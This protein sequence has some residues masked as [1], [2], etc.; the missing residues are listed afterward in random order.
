M[1]NE[2]ESKDRSLVPSYQEGLL[3]KSPD[4][5]RRGMDLAKT[6]NN[7]ISPIS[8][9]DLLV[10]ELEKV[11][12]E[13]MQSEDFEDNDV[14]D[15]VDEIIKLANQVLV[16]VTPSYLTSEKLAEIY[17]IRGFAYYL[18][19]EHKQAIKDYSKAIELDK[20]NISNYLGR[21]EVYRDSGKHKKAIKDYSRAIEL[22]PNSSYIYY[23]RGCVYQVLKDYKRAIKDYSRAIEINPDNQSYFNSREDVYKVMGELSL[24]DKDYKKAAE[25]E[26]EDIPF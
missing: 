6:L 18:S 4:L 20:N 13:F 15:L 23:E 1:N 3:K 21:A 9:I 2:N 22:D 5:L 16:L 26:L 7:T 24:A 25:L 19:W 10:T 8:D 11:Y 17:R 12:R 14:F